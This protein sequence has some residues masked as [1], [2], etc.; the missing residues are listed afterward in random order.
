MGSRGTTTIDFGA[1]PGKSDATATVTGESGILSSSLVEAW[2]LPADTADHTADE[3]VVDA[4]TITAGNLVV[5]VGFT[6]YAVARDGIPVPD[7]VK[8][9]LPGITVPNTAVGAP[10]VGD[11]APMPYGLWTVAWCW[12]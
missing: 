8:V 7:R 4:P 1:F 10:K 9:L 5:G 11:A 2:I 6:V 3:H 12:I